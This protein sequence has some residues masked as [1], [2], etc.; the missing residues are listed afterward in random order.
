V[1]AHNSATTT[2]TV[3]LAAAICTITGTNRSDT[4]T[5]TSGDDVICGGNGKDT[6]NGLGGNDIILGQ[7]GKDV[8]NG[9]EGNDTV[10]GGKGKDHVVGGPGVDAL[11]GGNAPTCSTRSTAPVAIR[12]WVGA[13]RTRARSTSATWR[14]ARRRM[15]VGAMVP[16]VPR[17]PLP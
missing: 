6:I 14:T 17:P 12:S 4:L 15:T 3:G 13:A 5:G 11:R 2:T 8:L 7:D 10:M 1:T 9:G 16:I